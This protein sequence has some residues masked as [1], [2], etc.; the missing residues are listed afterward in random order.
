MH[1]ISAHTIVAF[2]VMYDVILYVLMYMRQ[3][4]LHILYLYAL[5]FFHSH[6]LLACDQD[7]SGKKQCAHSTV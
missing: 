4:Y 1:H 3:G 7:Q 5:Y 2:F 6:L